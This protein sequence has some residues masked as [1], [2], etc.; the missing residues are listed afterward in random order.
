MF[1]KLSYKHKQKLEGYLFL[2][3][4]MIFLVGFI[5]YPFV[6]SVFRSFTDWNGMKAQISFTGIQNYVKLFT[7]TPAFWQAV[8]VNLKFTVIST[9]LQTVLGF[10]FAFLM[11]YMKKRWQRFYK[12]AFYVPVILPAAVVA[13]MWTFMLSS[14]TGLVNTIL[15][16]IGLDFLAHAWVGEKATALGSVIMVN[17]WQ[18]VGFTVVLYFLA[19]QGISPDVLEA[20]K[21]DGANK[22][23]LF[24]SFF[25]PLSKSTTETNIVL[26]I[27]GGMKSF[28]LFYLLTGGGPGTATKVVGMHIYETAF[29]N[30]RFYEALSMSSTLFAIILVLVMTVRKLLKTK[31]A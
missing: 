19:M 11:F 16:N 22:W 5:L 26:S 17:T 14:Q 25:I 20:A 6:Q 28:A 30:F 8:K 15:R 10:L 1:G 7:E 31:E 27:T 24:K 21:I 12:I 23:H 29:V 13:V 9:A 2:I 18:F 4:S 3:P